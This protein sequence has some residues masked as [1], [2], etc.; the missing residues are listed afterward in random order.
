MEFQLPEYNL[1]MMLPEIFLFLWAL[2]VLLFD[3]V[4]RRR[5][6]SAVGYLTMLGRLICGGL[7]ATTGYGRG[8]GRMFFSEPMALFFKII[9]LGSAFMAVG[10][11]FGI[12]KKSIVNHRGE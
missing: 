11:S 2:A 9:F 6:E 7:L 10:S 3:L 5:R 12:T 8:F 1:R 4:T